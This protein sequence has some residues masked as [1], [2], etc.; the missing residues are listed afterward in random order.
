MNTAIF[1]QR[2]DWNGIAIEV[3]WEPAWLTFAG[4]PLGHLQ[5][6][7]V[8]P[9]CAPLPITETGYRS[10]FI[11]A[12][13]VIADGGPL[14]YARAWLDHEAATPAWKS[15]AEGARQGTLF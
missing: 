4:H 5:I 9:E 6:Q 15:Q 1:T 13:D 11:P 12:C 3:R 8:A 2:I 10:H 7:S 14:A